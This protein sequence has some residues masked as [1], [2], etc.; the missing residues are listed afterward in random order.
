MC[1]CEREREA[2]MERYDFGTYR[3]GMSAVKSSQNTFVINVV[4]P[5]VDVKVTVSVCP[6]NI[7]ARS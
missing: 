4:A 1:V 7:T 2:A 5:F 6:K 3:N